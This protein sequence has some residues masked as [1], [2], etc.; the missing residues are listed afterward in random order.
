MALDSMRGNCQN[1][2]QQPRSPVTC[3]RKEEIL[4]SFFLMFR[5]RAK[6][7]FFERVVD[8]AM[9]FPGLCFVCRKNHTYA[10]NLGL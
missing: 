6:E 7:I 5:K 9:L 2:V 1:A 10:R 8:G 3:Y 4:I